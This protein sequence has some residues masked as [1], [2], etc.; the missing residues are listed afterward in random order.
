MGADRQRKKGWVDFA[1]FFLGRR[2]RQQRVD[3]PKFDHPPP[4]P[5]TCWCLPICRPEGV[6]VRHWGH[7]PLAGARVNNKTTESDGAT[8]LSSSSGSP[9]HLRLPPHLQDLGKRRQK[10]HHDFK[11]A[12][13]VIYFYRHTTTFILRQ[14]ATIFRMYSS[15]GFHFRIFRSIVGKVFFFQDEK[16]VTPQNLID[17]YIKKVLT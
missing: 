13:S 4:P 17:Q 1:E 12:G 3:R 11:N 10:A 5:Y 8:S 2:R 9:C 16:C 6:E 15:L 14:N 7:P